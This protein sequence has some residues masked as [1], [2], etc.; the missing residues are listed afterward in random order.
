[1]SDAGDALETLDDGH[2]DAARI[3]LQRSL[4]LVPRRS[5]RLAGTGRAVVDA[6]GL[7]ITWGSASVPYA[8]PINFGWPARG[9]RAQPFA[10][11]PL[12]RNRSDLE[13]AYTSAAAGI[14]EDV[15]D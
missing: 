11:E 12:E 8:G 13:A 1:M 7:H 10:T 14:L 5:G 9:I 6:Q 3:L 15:H 2:H 4:A